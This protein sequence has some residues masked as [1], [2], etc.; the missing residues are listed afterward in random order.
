[1]HKK[2]SLT[3]IQFLFRVLILEWI[4]KQMQVDFDGTPRRLEVERMAAQ[5]VL[6]PEQSNVRPQCHLSHAVCVEVKLVLDY[7]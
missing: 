1:M 3:N 4:V 2:K 6:Q 5:H 7:L